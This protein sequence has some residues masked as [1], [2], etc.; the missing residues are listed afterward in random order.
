MTYINR[1]VLDVS[2]HNDVTSWQAVRAAGIVGIIHKATE[3]TGYVD[4]QYQ[5]RRQQ[6]LQAGLVWGAYHFANGSDVQKQV[7]H[8][9][10]V[11]GIDAGTL[12]AL[13]WEE[14]PNGDTMSAGQAKEF[15]RLIGD[16]IGEYRCVVYSGNTAKEKL[17][18]HSDEY[19]GAHRL[20]LA[21]YASR[22]ITVQASWS[23]CWLWQYSDGNI[24]PTPHGCPGV[25]GEV[26]TNSWGGTDDELRQ[27]WAGHGREPIGPHNPLDEP[28]A[29]RPVVGMGDHS[30]DVSDL[31][32][33]INSTELR[34]DLDTDG[35]FGQLTEGAVRDYQ[36]SRGLEVDGIVGQ[37]TWTALY[38]G[39]APL[40]G[41]P[42]AFTVAEQEQIRQLALD[43][44]IASY[45]WR[46]RG[47]APNGYIAGMAL[48]F[49]QTYR[50]LLVGHPAARE[51]AKARTD[52][53][54]DALNIYRA[55]F[56][57]LQMSNETAGVDTLRHLYAL[58]L[59]SGMRESSG[60]HCEGRDQSA[61]N[62]TSDTAEAGLFQ[63][64]YN[65]HGASDP[66]FDNLMGEY[67]APQNEPACYLSAF[68][69]GVSCSSN[70]WS[71]YGSGKGCEFQKLCKECPAFAVE[72][73]GLTLRNLANHYGP[74]I[75]H[76]VELR[77]DA[78]MMFKSIQGYVDKRYPASA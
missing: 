19:F 75:R 26:D 64:S 31:Q 47:H 14:D 38:E 5:R 60:R 21:Q 28:L 42:S 67:S 25:S 59:G 53:D 8:F 22:H 37:Q 7:D 39:K 56:D 34:P 15:L 77:S 76:E 62:V 58:M 73:H 69:E 36:A 29:D 65:A 51:M 66:E 1:K 2:H 18:S 27:Q 17:G 4:D 50:K 30:H 41:P 20:W 55:K 63:T 57:D 10:N 9:L 52:S 71:N 23:D 32:I 12:Y 24:G 70:E 68:K 33:L 44:R 43:S 13:D 74:I 45:S 54:K 46:D 61:S 48:A 72:T 11:V 6:A 16:R 35:D 49:G 78:D 3:G 40:P